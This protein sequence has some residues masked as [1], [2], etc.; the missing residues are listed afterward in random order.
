MPAIIFFGACTEVAYHYGV[1][2]ACIRG[3]GWVLYTVM[4]VDPIEAFVAAA[5]IFLGPVRIIPYCPV[6][7]HK[8]I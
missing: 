7:P 3:I 1:L 8:K 6:I 5:N 4:D 2:Q